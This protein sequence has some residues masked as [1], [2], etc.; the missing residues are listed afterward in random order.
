MQLPRIFEDDKGLYPH[1]KGK[2]KISYSQYSSYKDLEYQNDYY[3]QYFSGIKLPSGEFA[4]FG[5]S[6]G[7]YIQHIGE[8]NKTPDRGC[9]SLE[10]CEILLSK[11]DYP[12]NCVYEEEVIID[13]GDFCAQGFIDRACYDGKNVEIRDYKSLNLSKPEKYESEDYNQTT[14]YCHERE[15]KGFT[16]TKSEVFGLGRKGSSLSGTGN[17]KMRLS[18][19]VKVIPTPYSKERAEKALKDLREVAEKISEDYKIYLKY[20]GSKNK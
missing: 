16:V 4:E 10:D 5:S 7:E 3:V 15:Q 2:P 11:V 6:C 20:F 8:K 9:L 17:F 13:C 1:L 19:E 14:L 18:G 12:N